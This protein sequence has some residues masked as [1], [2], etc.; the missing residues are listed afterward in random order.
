MKTLE[1]RIFRKLREKLRNFITNPNSKVETLVSKFRQEVKELVSDIRLPQNFS[2][3]FQVADA[4]FKFASNY[5][6]SC[7]IIQDKYITFLSYV[8]FSLQKKIELHPSLITPELTTQLQTLSWEDLV[9]DFKSA[10]A[11]PQFS[12]SLPSDLP[13]KKVKKEAP[14]P[15]SENNIVAILP[16]GIPGSGKSFLKT[17]LEKAV[18]DPEVSF[19]SLS[20]DQIKGVNVFFF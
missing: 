20:S 9:R 15:H 16:I 3:Y 17:F 10:K 18:T 6:K 13:I 4:A 19:H 12:S 11:S 8:L 2:F 1:Y 5:P 14:F 7:D